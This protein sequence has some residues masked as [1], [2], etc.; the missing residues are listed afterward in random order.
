MSVLNFFRGILHEH[1]HG[2]KDRRMSSAWCGNVLRMVTPHLWLCRGLLEQ[3]DQAD[4][5]RVA[6]TTEQNGSI[7]VVK[8]L[9]CTMED[10]EL[11]LS[12]ILPIESATDA[13]THP[14]R[15]IVRRPL[16]RRTGRSPLT[17]RSAPAG[18][19]SAGSRAPLLKPARFQS[20]CEAIPMDR[21]VKQEEQEQ[22]PA[23]SA[24]RIP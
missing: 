11:A 6:T 15:A 16:A 13:A 14:S 10:F 24:L 23:T 1:Q 2:L 3:L 7:K 9:E 21:Q 4:L 19:G 22:A 12:P 8:R 18:E 20:G 17:K 5:E